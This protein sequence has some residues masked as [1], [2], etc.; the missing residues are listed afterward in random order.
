MSQDIKERDLEARIGE[1]LAAGAATE[2]RLLKQERKAEKRLRD[3]LAALAADESRL[4]RAQERLEQSRENVAAAEAALRGSQELRAA[5]P[6]P[7]QD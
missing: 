7:N 2:Q 3:A 5:G 4:R 1:L 6:N